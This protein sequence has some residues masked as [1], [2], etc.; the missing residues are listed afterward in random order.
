M[1]RLRHGLTIGLVIAL[2]ACGTGERDQSAAG[3]QEGAGTA[4][5]STGGRR[6][7][8]GMDDQMGDMMNGGAM[9]AMQEHMQR[10][11]GAGAD[12]LQSMMP[13]H[14]QRT[15]NM[16]STMNRE[17]RDMNMTGDAAW[18]ATMDSIRQDLVRMPE[19]SPEE[20]PALM[21]AHRDRVMRLLA[22]H[23]SMMAN[24]KM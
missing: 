3:E 17:M 19:M 21:P 12:S 2:A 15:A 8:A 9:E 10:M 23:R 20:L 4:M 14:R 7:M 18:T 16:L 5:D 13:M 11:M 24:M 22:M 1:I 6:G